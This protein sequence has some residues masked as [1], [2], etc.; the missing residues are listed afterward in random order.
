MFTYQVYGCSCVL[1]LLHY[2]PQ[3]VSGQPS[4]KQKRE[5]SRRMGHHAVARVVY[6]QYLGPEMALTCILSLF[7]LHATVFSSSDG[8]QFPF[9]MSAVL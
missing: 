8:I 7:L 4:E 2:V 3:L 1:L 6:I 5:R 9:R